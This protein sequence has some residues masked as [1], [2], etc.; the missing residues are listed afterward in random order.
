MWPNPQETADLVTLPKKSLIENFIFCT[1]FCKENS[2]KDNRRVKV[3]SNKTLANKYEY[4]KF[5]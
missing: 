2:I 5:V 3:P 1:V 4:W